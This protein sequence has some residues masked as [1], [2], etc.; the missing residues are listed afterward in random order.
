MIKRFSLVF[1]SV[2]LAIS[3]SYAAGY[4]SQVLATISWGSGSGE[5]GLQHGQEL[6]TV[7]PT[8]FAIDNRGNI[9]LYD[10]VNKQIK[11]YDSSG[12]W[13]AN[14]GTDLLCS[15]FCIDDSG[16][17]Y[18]LDVDIHLVRVYSAKGEL[19]QE[20]KIDESIKLIEGYA[21]KIYIDADKKLMVNQVDQLVYPLATLSSSGLI[22]QTPTDQVKGIK[23]GYLG[24][25]DTNRYRMN[26]K[27]K[28]QAEII[29]ASGT[30][31]N[32]TGTISIESDD[33]LGAVL[34]LGQDTAGSNYT[35]IERT[36]AN[37]ILHLEVWKYNSARKL[38][39]TIEIPNDYFST[40]YKKLELDDA[41][42]IYQVQTKP[43]GVKVIKY[44]N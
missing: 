32:A 18:L 9:Y 15:S 4:Q 35:E 20:I 30:I 34:Y 17:L 1:F 22:N 26:W 23:L 6:E 39:D 41:G 42:N 40:V 14:L 5:I 3:V 28:H 25:A 12:K 31:N 44:S 21:Q 27:N 19:S 8:T 37:D 29:I 36:D 7:G 38:V 33:E 13:I 11:K 24:N 43:E 10:F 16:N 2:V